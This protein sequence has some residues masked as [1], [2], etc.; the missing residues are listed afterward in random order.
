[1][2]PHLY[3]RGLDHPKLLFQAETERLRTR[4]V[5]NK[6]GKVGEPTMP[7]MGAL[8]GSFASSYSSRFNFFAF[9]KRSTSPTYRP[10]SPPF[11]AASSSYS[12]PAAMRGGLEGSRPSMSAGGR[13]VGLHNGDIAVH[14]RAFASEAG[15]AGMG[16]VARA[17]GGLHGSPSAAGLRGGFLGRPSSPQLLRSSQSESAAAGRALLVPVRSL[18]QGAYGNAVVPSIVVNA[19]VSEDGSGGTPAAEGRAAAQ[20]DSTGPAPVGPGIR[21]A[22]VPN[23]RHGLATH[24]PLLGTLHL[25]RIHTGATG[26]H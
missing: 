3:D 8:S 11:G 4:L 15:R 9:G 6:E 10:P 13:L 7:G 17:V 12:I 19:A 23:M 25:A 26:E 20:L 1:M 5:K 22:S 16:F 14:G 24:D 18:H 21:F 2:C